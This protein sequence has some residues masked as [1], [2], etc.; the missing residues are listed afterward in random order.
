MQFLEPCMHRV[1]AAERAIQT[2]NNHLV[3]GLSTVDKKF[4]MQLWNEL[5]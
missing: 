1:N 2:C 4:S 5:L 3:A